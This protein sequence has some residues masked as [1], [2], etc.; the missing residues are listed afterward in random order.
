[1]VVVFHDRQRV[2][3][4]DELRD[5]VRRIE[6]EVLHEIARD[7]IDVHRHILERLLGA[8]GGEGVVGGPARL[9]LAHDDKGR[10]LNGLFLGHRR[11]GSSGDNLRSHRERTAS[12]Q[13]SDATREAAKW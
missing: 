10:E 8:R 9:A 4:G 1:M 13:P 2:D 6:A 11:S 3:V 7:G 12:E 5:V